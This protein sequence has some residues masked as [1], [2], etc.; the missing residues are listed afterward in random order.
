[1]IYSMTDCK[2]KVHY[3]SAKEEGLKGVCG[4]M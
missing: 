3:T 1:M 2:K 4:G